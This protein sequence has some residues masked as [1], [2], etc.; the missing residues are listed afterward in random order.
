MPRVVAL[1]DVNVDI[2]AHFGSFPA[3]GEDA[4][5]ASTE[6]HCGGSAANTAM[7]LARMGIETSLITRVGPDSWALKVFS[8]LSEAGVKPSGLQRDP[9]AMTGMMYVVVTPDGERTIL[10]HRGANVYTD[11]DAIDEADIHD[12]DLFH[13]SGYALLADPQRSAA[14][15]TLEAACRHNLIVSLDPGMAVPQKALEEMRALLPV[16]NILFPSLAEARHITGLDEPEECARALR[17]QGVKVVALKLGQAGCLIASGDTLF[18]VPGF[19]ITV[20]DSTGAGD[21]FAA[22]FL[23]GVLGD[24][25]WRGAA[26]LGNAMGAMCAACV[27]AGAAAPKARAVLELLREGHHKLDHP[28]LVAAVKQVIDYVTTLSTEPQ[29][30]GK[31]W[32]K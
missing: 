6:I 24:L 18:R 7:A 12:A 4:L 26:V 17:G 15:R 8:C 13:L 11:P 10:G 23:A 29:E 25:D 14:L 19:S 3:K 9:V 5:A 2:I 30:E 20:R 22:G 28:A 31:P 1:G 16:V 27:G 21:S 32:W